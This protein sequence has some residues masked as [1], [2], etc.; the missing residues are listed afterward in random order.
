[1]SSW[2]RRFCRT[3]QGL[4]RERRVGDGSWGKVGLAGYGPGSG[5]CDIGGKG[6]GDWSSISLIRVG[7]GRISWSS[8]NSWGSDGHG[9]GGWTNGSSGCGSWKSGGLIAVA[10]M[11]KAE[12]AK[13][14]I[15]RAVVVGLDVAGVVTAGAVTAGVVADGNFPAE[16][17]IEDVVTEIETAEPV[18]IR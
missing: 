3:R 16:T 11:T 8:R 12:K 2:C 13:F 6:G 5:G 10:L 1:M 9:S 7:C 17:L 14:V 18:A 15:V 4:E